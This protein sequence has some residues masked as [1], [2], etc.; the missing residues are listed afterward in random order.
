MSKPRHRRCET[1]RCVTSRYVRTQNAGAFS[2]QVWAVGPAGEVSVGNGSRFYCA[3]H[4]Q[5]ATR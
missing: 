4:G 3:E 1:C 5:Q 2:V